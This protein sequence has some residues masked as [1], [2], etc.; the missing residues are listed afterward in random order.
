[1]ICP[2]CEVGILEPLTDEKGFTKHFCDYCSNELETQKDMF[3]NKAL[4]SVKRRN[5]NGDTEC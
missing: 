4:A 5:K 2:V 3:Y 1:M